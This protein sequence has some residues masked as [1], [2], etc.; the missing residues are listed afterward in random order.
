MRP[1]CFSFLLQLKQLKQ[2]WRHKLTT[3]KVDKV[4]ALL[5]FSAE[6]TF[7]GEFSLT[8]T[9]LSLTLGKPPV[10]QNITNEL[11]VLHIHCIAVGKNEE[12]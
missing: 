10:S 1:N 9:N 8:L 4:Q 3:G 7:R 11:F 6:D 5:S 2:K 12:L